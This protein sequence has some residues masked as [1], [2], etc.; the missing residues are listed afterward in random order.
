MTVDNF[1]ITFLWG[2]YLSASHSSSLQ[3]SSPCSS[4][5]SGNPTVGAGLW[6][7]STRGTYCVVRQQEETSIADIV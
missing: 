6:Q 1:V 4:L 3:Y 5:C 2:I 7:V